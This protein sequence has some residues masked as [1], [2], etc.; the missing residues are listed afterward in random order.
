MYLKNYSAQD[1]QDLMPRTRKRQEED[2]DSSYTL[3]AEELSWTSQNVSLMCRSGSMKDGGSFQLFLMRLWVIFLQATVLLE[4]QRL[5]LRTHFLTG[6]TNEFRW[7]PH[8]FCVSSCVVWMF[9]HVLLK[10]KKKSQFVLQWLNMAL[11]FIS[12]ILISV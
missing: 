8:S 12:S 10:K 6:D 9:L 3:D 2:V 1:A 7:K 11:I 4:R 5:K